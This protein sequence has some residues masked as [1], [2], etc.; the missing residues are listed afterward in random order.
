MWSGGHLKDDIDE[1]LMANIIDIL[2]PHKH[3]LRRLVLDAHRM[4]VEDDHY[5][6]YTEDHLLPVGSLKDFTALKHM[7]VLR[8]MLVGLPAELRYGED[9]VE[10]EEVLV[11]QYHQELR[12]IATEM[13]CDLG[14]FDAEVDDIF[15]QV[16]TDV[17]PAQL[18]S[19]VIRENVRVIK[20]LFDV[21]QKLSKK[22]Q[23]V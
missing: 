12:R 16:L 18:E 20:E 21:F 23:H 2:L 15:M 6:R 13:T 7:D 9:D 11:E 4:A 19:L 14:Y 10:E 1:H 8:Y 17:F 22:Q 3:C 5:V